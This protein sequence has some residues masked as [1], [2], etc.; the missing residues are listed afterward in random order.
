MTRRVSEERR[1]A[2]ALRASRQMIAR[3]ERPLYRLQVQHGYWTVDGMSWLAVIAA[4]R[5]EALDSARSAI[6]AWLDAPA[7]GFDVE[8]VPKAR[9]AKSSDGIGGRS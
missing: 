7:E 9:R 2:A 3:G 1:R 4:G 5:R 6:A 8:V